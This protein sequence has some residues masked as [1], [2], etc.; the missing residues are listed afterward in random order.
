MNKTK[1]QLIRDVNVI[2]TD[3]LTIVERLN[4]SHI[5]RKPK[6]YVNNYGGN[7]NGGFTLYFCY[8]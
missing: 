3:R 6:F 4:K 1:G 2:E 8:I 5:K 7:K